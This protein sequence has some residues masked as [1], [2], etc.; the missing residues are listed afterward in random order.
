MPVTRCVFHVKNKAEKCFSLHA[1]A[2]KPSETQVT[3]SDS[4]PS[5]YH[6]S[7]LLLNSSEETNTHHATSVFVKIR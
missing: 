6:C 1:L 4:H 2:A 3:H 7:P 5:K